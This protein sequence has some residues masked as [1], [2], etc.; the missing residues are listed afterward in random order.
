MHDV[1]KVIRE[2]RQGN[3][4]MREELIA[5]YNTFIY[6][7]TSFICK[8]KLDWANDDELSIA[9]IAFNKAIDKFETDREHSFQAYARTLIKNSLIDYFRK[10]PDCRP[11]FLTASGV[12]GQPTREELEISLDY[13]AKDLENRDRAFELQLFKEELSSFGLILTELPALS[14]S[15]R[16][17]REYLNAAA[18]KIACNEELVREIYRNKKL[19][20]KEIQVLTGVTKKNLERWRKY[21]VTLIIILTNPDLGI[22]AEYIQGKEG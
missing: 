20:L 19:P 21:L 5:S 11:V 13:Y 16:E 2:I 14:P 18:Q 9:L 15:H 17:T 8:R 1:E 7:Y 3:E 22:L 10:Q 12:N 4:S 6:K